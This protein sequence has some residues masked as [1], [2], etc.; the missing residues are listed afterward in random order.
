MLS[1]QPYHPAVIADSNISYPSFPYDPPQKYPELPD[2][3]NTDST[4][5]L[6]TAVREILI[7]LKLDEENYNTPGWNPFKEFIKPNQSILIKPNW[8]LDYNPIDESIDSLITHSSIIRTVIDYILK[9]LNYAGQITIADAPLQMCDFDS[10]LKKNRCKDLIDLYASKFLNVSFTIIDMRKTVLKRSQSKIM[11][12][13]NQDS[14]EGDPKGYTLVDLAGESL[15]KDIDDRYER[16]RV[17]CYDHNLLH[18]HHNREKHE[19]LISNSI[20]EADA[21]INLPKMKCHKKAGLTGALKNLI[22]INGHKEYLPH[23]I[24]GSFVEGGDQ[25]IYPSFFKKTYNNLYD[26][27]WSSEI[28]SGKFTAITIALISKAIRTFAIDD[29]LEGS[30]FGNET[31]PRTTIDLNH[32]AY[33]YDIQ[34]KTLC[35]KQQRPAFHLLD[36]IVA[37]EGNGPLKPQARKVGVLIGGFNP[38]MVDSAM[39]SMLGYNPSLIKTL[40]YAFSHTK[41]RLVRTISYKDFDQIIFENKLTSFDS[42]PDF[43]FKKPK[44]WE[45][46]ERK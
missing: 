9:A 40:S 39:A 27:Y 17:T 37:G 14:K 21:I 23:H 33:Y 12:K 8:V 2:D 20:L 43:K 41:S 18:K 38:V 35:D 30:W 13:S 16:F 7:N 31:I 3:T 29:N 32:I 25:Y 10:M 19:Y 6:Y 42:L 36:G 28:C 11:L 34:N 24:N 26:K 15:L 4:N 44:F 5:K 1:I 45:Q 46:S 22:G